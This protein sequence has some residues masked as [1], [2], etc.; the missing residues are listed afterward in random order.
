MILQELFESD[1]PTPVQEKSRTQV[2]LDMD[3]VLADFFEEYAKLAGNPK[4]G[5]G[6]KDIWQLQHLFQPFAWRSR[7]QRGAKTQMVAGQSRS[8]TTGSDNHTTETKI[9]C[10]VR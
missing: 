9:C 7:K 2:Y 10:A 5:S 3:G 1:A 8:A 6:R 4:D